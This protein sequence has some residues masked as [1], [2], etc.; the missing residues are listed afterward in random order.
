MEG[1]PSERKSFGR[2]LVDAMWRTMETCGEMWSTVE[3]FSYV[4]QLSLG[5]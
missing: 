1:G 4:P 2:D 5:D 3:H